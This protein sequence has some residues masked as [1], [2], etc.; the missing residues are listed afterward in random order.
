MN[1]FKKEALTEI[2]K[3]IS[4]PFQIKSFLNDHEIKKLLEYFK[5]LK[6]KLVD[7]DES[8]KIAFNFDDNQILKNIEI[9]LKDLI[10]EF[11]VN[12]F[13]PHYFDSRYPLR[14]HADTGKNPNDIIYKNILIPL[15]INSK[16]NSDVH[17]IIFKNMWF[18]QSALFTTKTKDNYD[19][20]IKD[21]EGNFRDIIDIRRFLEVLKSTKQNKEIFY[22]SGKYFNDQY[23]I[24]Y[25]QTLCRGKRYNIRTDKHIKSNAQFDKKLYDKYLS[26]QPYEDLKG[27]EIKKIFKWKPGNLLT[28]DRVY[29][30][31]SDNFIKNKN[32][33]SKAFIAIFT[34]KTN[35]T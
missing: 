2:T 6:T 29:I 15:E 30:H 22:E 23:F 10:G 25:I 9:K 11:Y 18:G 33:E 5:N 1:F 7:R 3:N 4:D 13:K 20:I 8:T 19:Y 26:H 35:V 27:M 12:D 16:N 14:I 31:S 32:I 17:T 24:D 34:S 28:W 21:I